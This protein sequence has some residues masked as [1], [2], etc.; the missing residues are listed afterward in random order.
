MM[1]LVF[2]KH[3][4]I[5]RV[6][7]RQLS[8]VFHIS[9]FILKGIVPQKAWNY[10]RLVKVLISLSHCCLRQYIS[11]KSFNYFTAT[12]KIY[13]FWKV[14]W[15]DQEIILIYRSCTTWFCWSK[16]LS[17]F[18]CL[19]LALLHWHQ[20]EAVYVVNKVTQGLTF[21]YWKQYLFEYH[22]HQLAF[23]FHIFVFIRSFKYTDMKGN[24]CQQLAIGYTFSCIKIAF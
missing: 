2:L 11:K 22:L 12:F 1:Y 15:W 8:V 4:K 3:T 16:S 19:L 18:S 20:S 13:S 9:T 23:F 7:F 5:C 10:S 24:N 6:K 17:D 14:N 21:P